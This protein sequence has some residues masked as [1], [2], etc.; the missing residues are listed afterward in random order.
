MR[1]LLTRYAMGAGSGAAAALLFLTAMRGAPLGV[2]LAY[3]GPL[4]LMIATLGWGLDAGLIALLCACGLAA[5]VSPP[6]ALVYGLLVAGPAYGLA[7]FVAKPAAWARKPADPEAPRVYPGPAAV[8]M[9]AAGV[10]ILAGCVQITLMW[11]ATGGYEAA[12]SALAAEIRTALDASGATRALPPDMTPD[13]LAEAFVQ[14][15]PVALS[16]GA[17]LMQLANLY[18]AARS[19]QLSQRLGRPWRDIPSGYRLPRWLGLAAAAAAALAVLA[20][21]PFEDYGLVAT[22]A[23]GVLYALH[24]LAAL[25]ALS[26]RAAARPFLLA[27]LYFACAVAAQWVLPALALLGIGESFADLR[28]RAAQGVKTRA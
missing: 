27:A 20:P 3:L 7:A 8:A 24:G 6:Y 16:T 9:L 12:V 5:A 21:T 26:R 25:H 19:V 18:L 14:F 28:G 2:A 10:F 23:L 17:T 1:E 15:A 11:F 22:G 13:Q 4:P